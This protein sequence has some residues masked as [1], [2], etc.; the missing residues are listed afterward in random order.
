M[1]KK[2]TNKL[3]RISKN[4][5]RESKLPLAVVSSFLHQQFDC[6][7]VCIGKSNPLDWKIKAR[8]QTNFKFLSFYHRD[9]L[10]SRTEAFGF[11][12]E[13]VTKNSQ[14]IGWRMLHADMRHHIQLKS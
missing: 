13:S 14:W 1:K 4:P 12:S 6:E 10:L 9:G 7:R 2:E 11:F 8:N 5:K 3:G